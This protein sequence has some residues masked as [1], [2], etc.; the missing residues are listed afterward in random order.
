MPA[1]PQHQTRPFGLCRELKRH[2]I[3]VQNA[4]VSSSPG[5]RSDSGEYRKEALPHPGVRA[6]PDL[7]TRGLGG[8]VKA[9]VCQSTSGLREPSCGYFGGTVFSQFAAW[10]MG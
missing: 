9:G 2:S 8:G 7:L 10:L 4:A 3:F 1:G 6:R 5:I